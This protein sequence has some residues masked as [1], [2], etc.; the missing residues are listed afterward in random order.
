MAGRKG[1]SVAAR[2]VAGAAHQSGIGR[3]PTRFTGRTAEAAKRRTQ[4]KKVRNNGRLLRRGKL[5]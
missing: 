5:R 3:R 2:A 4:S 1:Y